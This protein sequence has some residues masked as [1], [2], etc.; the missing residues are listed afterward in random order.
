MLFKITIMKTIYI[1]SIMLILAATITCGLRAQN[2]AVSRDLRETP[3]LGLKAGI[4]I[5]NLYD[6]R[7]EDFEKTSKVGF[8]G[9]AFLSLPIGRYLGVQPEVLYSKKGYKGSGEIINYSFTRTVDYLD[10]PLLLQL[11]PAQNITIVGGPLFSFLLHKRIELESGNLSVEQQTDIKNTNFRK[12]TLGL[13]GG[14]DITLYPVVISGR[15]GWDVQHNNGDG[16]STDPRFKN[17][18]FQTTVGI[19]F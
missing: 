11:K 18:W 4:N 14:L 19:V 9:G 7:G 8:A 5:S 10:I 12:N 3:A 2:S 17:V 6:T 1:K 16:T 15:V 13:T